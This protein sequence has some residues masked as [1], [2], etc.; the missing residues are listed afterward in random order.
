M[1]VDRC[2][3]PPGHKQE[4]TGTFAKAHTVP[5][6]SLRRIAARGHVFSFVPNAYNLVRHGPK[7]PPQRL[8][9]NRASTFTGF[10]SKHDDAIFAP[11]EKTPFAGT[12]EQ[13]FLLAYRALARELHLKQSTLEYWDTRLRQ[14]PALDAAPPLARFTVDAFLRGSRKGFADLASHKADYDRILL[15]GDY[16]DVRAH[17]VEVSRPPS[18]MC[19]GGIVPEHTFDGEK[20]IDIPNHPQRLSLLSFS[21]FAD[22]TAGFVVFAW[23]DDGS[24]HC[25]R[26]ARSL[27]RLPTGILTASLVRFFFECCENVHL[28]PSWWQGLPATARDRLVAR[29]DGS[30]EFVPRDRARDFH[31]DDGVTYGRWD[32]VRR[33]DVGAWRTARRRHPNARLPDDAAP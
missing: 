19:S 9:V 24:D 17:V 20:L 2:S 30:S 31:S 27:K 12:P 21:S 4:C 15:R 33:Y 8:G 32:I 18:V 11:L 13:C 5:R 28:Q 7:F 22:A 26:L 25:D 1:S 10:C 29:M 23:V 16:H 3:A 14:R 6:A